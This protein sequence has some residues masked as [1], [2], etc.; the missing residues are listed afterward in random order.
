[1]H[2]LDPALQGTPRSTPAELLGG[3]AEQ[4]QSSAVRGS[5]AEA[6]PGLGEF[7]LGEGQHLA[8]T[9]LEDVGDAR[10]VV[11]GAVAH[12]VLPVAVVLRVPHFGKRAQQGFIGD[13]L[14]PSLD[15]D[16]EAGLPAVVARGERALIVGAQVEG[17]L[18]A[19]TGAEIERAVAPDRR[20]R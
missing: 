17:F 16:V 8:G 13:P 7:A 1:M 9:D 5:A 3:A 15:D 11:E 20:E 18:L 2:A 4:A 12:V 10:F 19:G 14:G 6:E